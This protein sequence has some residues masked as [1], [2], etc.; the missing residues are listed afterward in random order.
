MEI[1][2]S[3]VQQAAKEG[4]PLVIKTQTVPQETDSLLMSLLGTYLDE[5][6]QIDFLELLGHCL[7]E[8]VGNAKMANL[9]RVHFDAQNLRI[10]DDS[11]YAEGM[12]TWN[13]A[14]DRSTAYHERLVLDDRCIRVTYLI[15][16]QVLYLGVRNTSKATPRELAVVRATLD[17]AW[18]ASTVVESV[19]SGLSSLVF[20]LRRLGLDR[21]SFDFTV[22]PHGT[23]A[24]LKIP[25]S[26]VRFESLH[27]VTTEIASAVESIPPFPPNLTNLF[28]LLE[29]PEVEFRL[30]AAELAQDPAMTADLIKYINSASNRGYKRIDTLEEA[31]RLVGTRGLK[32]L[33]Y[34]YGAHKILGKYLEK[35]RQL[36]ENAVRVARYAVE[37]AATYR[38]DWIEKG[39]TQIVGLLYNLGQIVLT[40]LYPQQSLRILEFCREKRLSIEAFDQLTQSIN[41]ATLG[42][43]IAEKWNFP[44]ELVLVLRH[45]RSPLEAPEA[46]QR[47]CA[48]VGLASSLRMVELELLQYGQISEEI[49][50]ILGVDVGQVVELH[51]RFLASAPTTIEQFAFS[52][53]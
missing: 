44:Q 19:D 20:I 10:D 41:P 52:S 23:T 47:A 35:Q 4:I 5:L 42:A 9:L 39:Q 25:M 1:D 3:R 36:W 32:D 34:P 21:R 29:D 14:Q 13:A 48:A 11:D 7:R 33:M 43:S 28:R 6:G 17:R 51:Q 45:Q 24:T 46:L 40:F 38:F 18:K 16:N 49:L 27:E 15:Q 12:K 2:L 50:T 31:I 53:N 8:L 22:G 37:L 30:L 26:R